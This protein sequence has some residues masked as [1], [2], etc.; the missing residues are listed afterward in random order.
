LS[1]TLKSALLILTSP[2]VLFAIFDLLLIKNSTLYPMRARALHEMET[3]KK[4]LNSA[5]YLIH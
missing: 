3:G 2:A 4:E 1:D 5:C